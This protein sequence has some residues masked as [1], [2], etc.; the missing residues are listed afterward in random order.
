M[1]QLQNFCDFKNRRGNFVNDF[2]QVGI[3]TPD[4]V[5]YIYEFF[6]KCDTIRVIFTYV[7]GNTNELFG[8]NTPAVSNPNSSKKTFKPIAH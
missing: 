8:F 6:L 4:K 5:S 3:G 1:G 7:T 2:R